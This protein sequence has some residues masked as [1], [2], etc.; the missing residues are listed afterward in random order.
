MGNGGI[1]ID[2]LQHLPDAEVV[3]SK[4]IK[5]DVSPPQGGFRQVKNQRFLLRG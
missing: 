1:T 3:F 4:L 2:N 5:R